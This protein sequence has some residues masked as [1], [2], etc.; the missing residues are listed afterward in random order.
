MSCGYP[1][2]QEFIENRIKDKRDAHINITVGLLKRIEMEA[3]LAEKN[4]EIRK[5]NL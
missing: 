5:D 2:R 4:G 3:D 1:S